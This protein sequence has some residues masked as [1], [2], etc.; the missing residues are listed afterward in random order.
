MQVV[1]VFVSGFGDCDHVFNADAADG[2]AVESRFDGEDIAC[3]DFGAV[4]I[5]QWW[6]VD[7]ESDAVPGAVDHGAVGVW[8]V[9]VGHG[10]A[11]AVVGDDFDGGF[12]D[13]LAGDACASYALGGVFG[14]D[15]DSVHACDF[16]GDVAVDDGAGAI[17]V[18]HGVV[19]E[20]EKVDD[21]RLC[22]FEFAGSS[23]V[24]VGADGAAGD[25]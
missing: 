11:V 8:C 23:M 4:D 21:D 15:N 10:G 9:V 25:D 17:A 22:G 19:D 3:D 20:R 13:A 2:F 24:A 7:I 12:V 1:E 14:L 16:I 6:F 5:E 18:V